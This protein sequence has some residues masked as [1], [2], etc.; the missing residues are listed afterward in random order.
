MITDG[1]LEYDD[2]T[3][4]NLTKYGYIDYDYTVQGLAKN[5]SGVFDRMGIDIS[6]FEIE[7]KDVT[8]E[9]PWTIKV[10][11]EISYYFIDKGEVA[12]WRGQTTKTALIPVYGLYGFDYE[13][14]YTRNEQSNIGLITDSWI[15]DEGP[16]Y[17]EPSVVDKLSKR[18]TRNGLGIC[19]PDF[20]IVG[21]TC[22]NDTQ[23]QH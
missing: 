11:A 20:S 16:V 12:S 14:D 8:Q 22:K 1:V 7:I 10:E 9:D 15:I 21:Y 4:Y 5:I 23:A 18:F 13:E 2:G 6:E 3:S 19:S 17:T